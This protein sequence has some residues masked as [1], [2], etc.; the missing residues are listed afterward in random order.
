KR[1]EHHGEAI[2]RAVEVIL[3]RIAH[4]IAHMDGDDADQHGQRNAD[5]AIADDGNEISAVLTGD[6]DH[7]IQQQADEEDIAQPGDALG[8]EVTGGGLCVAIMAARI[9]DHVLGDDL[10]AHQATHT[11][12]VQMRR[13]ISTEAMIVPQAMAS[14]WPGSIMAAKSQ[15]QWRRPPSMWCTRLQVKLNSTSCPNQLPKMKLTDISASCPIAA[16]ASQITNRAMP[17]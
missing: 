3:E 13:V 2:H 12:I 16:A 10:F 15:T 4:A 1:I 9:G 5:P 7:Q 11:K 6:T 8:N 17:A 14:R